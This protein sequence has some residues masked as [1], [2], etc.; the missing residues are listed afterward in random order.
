MREL[1]VDVCGE[2]SAHVCAAIQ[3]EPHTVCCC[4]VLCAFRI[5]CAVL[6]L[7]PLLSVSLIYCAVVAD[8]IL[9]I[10]CIL[11]QSV[12]W[13]GQVYL[14]YSV[15]ILRCLHDALSDLSVAIEDE[16]VEMVKATSK[17]EAVIRHCV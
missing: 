16:D 6:L 4:V 3:G 14:E 1:Q 12:A 9:K 7:L 10:V 11:W 17:I 8:C 5:V 2:R 13:V 15:R